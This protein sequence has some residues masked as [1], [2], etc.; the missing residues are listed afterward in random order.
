[1][2]TCKNTQFD[3]SHST[4]AIIAA[5]AAM[6]PPVLPTNPAAPPVLSGLSAENDDVLVGEAPSDVVVVTPSVAVVVAPDD[7]AVLE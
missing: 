4:A 5:T 1:M 7:V 3:G 6:R 2:P